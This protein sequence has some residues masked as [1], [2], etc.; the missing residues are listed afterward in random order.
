M[1]P[2]E[3]ILSQLADPFRIGLVVALIAT[4]QR[5]RAVTGHLVPLALGVS[6][7]AIIIPMTL[8]SGDAVPFLM[9]VATGIVTNV[10]LLVAGLG[11]L[12]LWQR[13]RRG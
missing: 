1:T 4:M 5:T 9:Q 12:A 13:L 3:I 2:L 11:L 10:L 6:F 8:T 7:I